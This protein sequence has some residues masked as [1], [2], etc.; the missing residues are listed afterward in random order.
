MKKIISILLAVMLVV[1]VAAVSTGAVEYNPSKSYTVS[2]DTPTC[3]EAIQACGGSIARKDVQKIYFQLPLVDPNQNGSDWK[4][5]F[6]SEDLGLDYCQTCVYWWTGLAGAADQGW[7]SGKGCTWVGYKTKLVDAANRI[8]EA[9]VPATGVTTMI[10]DNGVDAG[11]DPN[12][13]MF[14]FGRQIADANIEGAEEGDYDTL[15]EGT[16]NPDNMDGCIQ[17]IDYSVSTPNPLTGFDSYGSTWYVYYGNG[18]YGEVL[19]T[20]D[21]YHWRYFAC[22]NPEH[23]HNPGDAS[24]DGKVNILDVFCIQRHLIKKD[25]PAGSTWNEGNADADA[26]AYVSIIDATRIQRYKAE[27]CNLDG[28]KPY[29]ASNPVNPK[30]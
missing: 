25:M 15:P 10:W 27:L 11:M 6:N 20:S 22:K 28:S 1:S 19:T 2:K 12:A 8:Y 16:P 24:S 29:S 13:P 5:K 21:D 14:K 3:E 9:T 26:D 17:I 23:N 7:P 18:C 30:A 4:N